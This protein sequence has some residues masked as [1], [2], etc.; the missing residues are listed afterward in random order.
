MKSHRRESFDRLYHELPL[1]VQEG[2]RRAYLMWS[3]NHWHPSLRFK[4]MGGSRWSVRVGAHHRAVGLLD[5][6]TITWFWIGTHEEYNK[7][8]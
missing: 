3:R 4:P 5:G 6:E 7:L 2:A 8:F 1:N